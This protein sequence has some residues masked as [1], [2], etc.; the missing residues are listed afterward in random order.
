MNRACQAVAALRSALAARRDLVLEI[1]ALRHQLSVLARS[2]RR[3]RPSDR[4]LWLLL[5]RCW[6]QWREALVL[7]QPATVDRWH[8]QGFRRCWGRRPRRPGRPRID[9][10]CRDLIRRLAAENCL[11]GAPRIH[12]ELLKLGIAVSERTVSRYLRGRRTAP[13]QAWCTFLVNHFG[14][15]AFISPVASSYAASD[16]HVVDAFGLSFRPA[17]FSRDAAFACTQWAALDSP[18]SLPRM[19]VELPIA[20]GHLDDRVR[21]GN[22]AGRDPPPDARSRGARR[23]HGIR[24][25]RP[26]LHRAL[27]DQQSSV[28]LFAGPSQG[29]HRPFLSFSLCGK[30]SRQ[31]CLEAETS[32]FG[33][34]SGTSAW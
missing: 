18:R 13:S 20:Q 1:L 3:F 25:L 2:T 5:R 12:G 10:P 17:P 24:F 27:C 4:L 14:Q 23:A 19:S 28:R 31:R 8:R 29:R 9:S 6:P 26:D 22:R 34:S 7:V 16:E 33:R 11:W 15:L 30:S 32:S 21:T